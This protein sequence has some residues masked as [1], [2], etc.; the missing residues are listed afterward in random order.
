MADESLQAHK[1]MSLSIIAQSK[2]PVGN[3][4]RATH[5]KYRYRRAAKGWVAGVDAASCPVYNPFFNIHI[6]VGDDG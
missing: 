2:Y 3:T 5:R 4:G 1:Q 6:N